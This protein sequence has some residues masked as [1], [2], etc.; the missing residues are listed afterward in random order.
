MLAQFN[1]STL[2]TTHRPIL[3]YSSLRS[4]VGT[5]IWFD[6]R[7]LRHSHSRKNNK[8]H[9]QL[10]INGELPNKRHSCRL[11]LLYE[12][13]LIETPTVHCYHSATSAGRCLFSHCARGK[14]KCLENISAKM[15]FRRRNEV[16]TG[17]LLLAAALA[18]WVPKRIPMT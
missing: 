9:Q 13:K 8:N 10:G 5:W 3:L 7:S 14:W 18:V 2:V 11:Q 15:P 6:C 1:K 12:P 4:F 16:L 17:K